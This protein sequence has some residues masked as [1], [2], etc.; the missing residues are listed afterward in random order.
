MTP[1][2]AYYVMVATDL[3]RRHRT[4]RYNSIV[5]R[6]SLLARIVAGLEMLVGLGRPATTQP[7]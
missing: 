1:I 4:H 2:A 6:Q 7:V 5:P 3:E